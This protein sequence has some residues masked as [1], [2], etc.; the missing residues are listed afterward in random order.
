MI[1]LACIKYDL[2]KQQRTVLE[3]ISTERECQLY[4]AANLGTSFEIAE[5]KQNYDLPGLRRSSFTKRSLHQSGGYVITIVS[6]WRLLEKNRVTA[7]VILVVE[8]RLCPL[9]HHALSLIHI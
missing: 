8:Q 2:G 1:C 9:Q 7:S 4:T 5:A 3:T 6:R